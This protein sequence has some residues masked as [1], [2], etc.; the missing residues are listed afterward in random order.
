MHDLHRWID[1]HRIGPAD[2]VFTRDGWPLT[3]PV[4]HRRWS[5]ALED[6]SLPYVTIRSARHFFATRLADA[7][8]PEDARKELMGH[9]SIG[10]TAGYTHWPLQTLAALV[11][12]ADHAIEQQAQMSAIGLS[13]E[14]QRYQRFNP[15]Q[16]PISAHL[17]ESSAETGQAARMSSWCPCILFQQ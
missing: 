12:K 17:W 9:V 15:S 11:G 3:N 8:A 4:E 7:G 2:L 5:M 16:T 13:L 14:F 1:E 10:T 6:A